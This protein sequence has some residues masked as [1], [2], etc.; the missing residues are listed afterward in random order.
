[1]I[2]SFET[3]ISIFVQEL[4]GKIYR[5]SIVSLGNSDMVIHAEGREYFIEVKKYY[6][7]RKFEKGKKQ[8]AYYVKRAGLQ[9]GVYIVFLRNNL[10]EDLP[11]NSSEII[12]NIII[13]TYIIRYDEEKDF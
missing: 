3:F 1:M 12:D 9:Q 4:E 2:Y 11:D 13:K 6:S 7:P 10:Y 5:E 8:L